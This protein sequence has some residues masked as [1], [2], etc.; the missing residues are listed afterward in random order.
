[1]IGYVYKTTHLTNNK[2][3]VG[4]HEA[5]VF[6]PNK[7]IGSG[8]IL[9]LAI[10][11]Q[12]EICREKGEDWHKYFKC[13]LIEAC[14]SIDELYGREEF[15]IAELDARNPEVG[16]NLSKGGAVPTFKG[17]KHTAE[18]KRKIGEASLGRKHT[19]EA[20]E[21]IKN[22]KAKNPYIY[23][24][25]VRAK[26][27][28]TM[29]GKNLGHPV[30]QETRDKISKANKGKHGRPCPDKGQK[31]SPEFCAKVK[32]AL[33]T[34]PLKRCKVICVEENLIFNSITEAA[35]WCNGNTA[36]IYNSCI[37][38]TKN[39]KGYHWQYVN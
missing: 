2:I 24:D 30:S 20:I 39:P 28:Q 15:W 16:Y 27:S 5:E 14:A 1:M 33:K 34:A 12:R 32:E 9:K 35:Q 17:Y 19:P 10:K 29:T 21:K 22:T 37:G 25:A 38:K 31:R 23:T 7:Y 36:T 3:Y 11:K 4:K 13:E 26:M 6:E 8:K 18:A